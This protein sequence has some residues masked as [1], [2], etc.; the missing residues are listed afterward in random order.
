VFWKVMVMGSVSGGP[1][2]TFHKISCYGR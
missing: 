2:T 1:S